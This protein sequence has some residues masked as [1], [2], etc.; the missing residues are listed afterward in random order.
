MMQ[1]TRCLHPAP[2]MLVPYLHVMRRPAT[3]ADLKGRTKLCVRAGADPAL[4]V[5]RSRRGLV[6]VVAAH[7]LS[8]KALSEL[9]EAGVRRFPL[10]AIPLPFDRN[11]SSVSQACKAIAPQPV[12]SQPKFEFAKIWNFAYT[13]I[14]KFV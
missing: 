14:R 13:K 8:R 2:G 7:V 6:G 1:L 4:N 12:P 5:G 10:P 11:T 9:D 3:F